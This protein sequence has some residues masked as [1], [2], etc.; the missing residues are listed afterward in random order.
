MPSRS[1]ERWYD[2]AQAPVVDQALHLAY[3]RVVEEGLVDERAPG[4]RPRRR[5]PARGR[6]PP[7]APAASR[8]RRACPRAAPRAPWR[9][10]ATAA[11]RPGPRRRRRARAARRSR[12]CSCRPGCS[13]RAAGEP[14]RVEIAE[15]RDAR[16]GERAR[17]SGAGSCP[18]TPLPRWRCSGAVRPCEH[19]PHAEH[20]VARW[21]PRSGSTLWP[22]G[23]RA[24]GRAQREQPAPGPPS[25]SRR[26]RRATAR[27]RPQPSAQ[28]ARRRRVPARAG[29]RA[30][31][32]PADRAGR[33]TS[34]RARSA[35]R[36]SR[37]ADPSSA[38]SDHARRRRTPR[39]RRQEAVHAARQ[40]RAGDHLAPIRLEP[41]AAVVHRHAA[42]PATISRFATRDGSTRVTNVLL[43]LAA[44]A[45]HRVVAR[46][47]A[48]RAAS[49]CRADRSARRRR[50]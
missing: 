16:A 41:A 11:S 45:A 44:P 6:R 2:V 36:R 21:R 26:R 25:A 32:A 19:P 27:G 40:L 3:Q 12:P 10:G 42:W 29:A 34:V 23:R 39:M 7:A 15:G 50:A 9:G 46:A 30:A 18:S 17:R 28:H 24:H 1:K 20:A 31:A 37:A 14:S 33:R 49:G 35:T 47:R 8:P 5:R 4:W 22:I 43:A 13:A 38:T 48:S